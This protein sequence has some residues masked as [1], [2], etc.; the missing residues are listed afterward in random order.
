MLNQK[1]LDTKILKSLKRKQK[2]VNITAAANTTGDA[3]LTV[4]DAELGLV[5]GFAIGGTDGLAVAQCYFETATSIKC[6]VRNLTAYSQTGSFTV[7]Y[8]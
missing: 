7:F 8:L 2:A 4:S 6:R 1:K 5:V 3:S